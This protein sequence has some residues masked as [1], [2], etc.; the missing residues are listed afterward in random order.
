MVRMVLGA[1]L[2]HMIT[3]KIISDI[4]GFLIAALAAI[5][6]LLPFTNPLFRWNISLIDFNFTFL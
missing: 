4:V 3:H 1:D 6:L 2:I 5:I